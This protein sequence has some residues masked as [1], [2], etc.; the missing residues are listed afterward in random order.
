MIDAVLADDG[1][2][3]VATL[4][5]EAAGASVAIVLPAVGAAVGSDGEPIGAVVLLDD[6]RPPAAGSDAVLRLAAV[7]ALALAAPTS[8]AP[9]APTCP[10]APT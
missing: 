9:S 8:S 5:A 7:A 2:D 1:L 10:T 6:G 4:T 3:A